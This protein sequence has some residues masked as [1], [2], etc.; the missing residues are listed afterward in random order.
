MTNL[1][2]YKN[3][4]QKVYSEHTTILF[5]Q[6]NAQLNK[7]FWEVSNEEIKCDYLGSE[8]YTENGIEIIEKKYGKL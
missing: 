1:T 3:K 2:T 4:N 8:S 5:I 6:T 7:N